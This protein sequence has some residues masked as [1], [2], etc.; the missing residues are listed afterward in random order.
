MPVSLSDLPRRRVLALL[1]SAA[2]AFVAA[3]SAAA[4][5]ASPTTPSSAH[6][7]L[8][9][10]ST[11]QEAYAQLI[12]AFQQTQAGTGV[13]IDTSFGASGTQTQ[14]VINGL[15]ADVVALSLE[16]D[17]NKLV[18]AG[19]VAPEWN[20]DANHGM[21]TDSVVVLVVRKGNPRNIRDW[22]DLL[23]PGVDVVTPDA[24]Q[25]GGAK[26]NL[27]AAY[28]AQVKQGASPDAAR[29]YL[30][31]LLGH[32]NVQ[33]ASARE[34]MTTFAGG[35]GDVLI[36]YENEAITAQHASQP[37]DYVVPNSTILIENPIAITRT[38]HNAAAAQAFVEYLRSADGQR[39]W[40]RLGYRPILQDIASEFASSFRVPAGQFTIADLGGWPNVDKQFF[41]RD[42]GMVSQILQELGRSGAR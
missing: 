31:G 10:Y 25:S 18:N 38:S 19:I 14:A 12:P 36:A 6:L 34:A 9:G 41:D 17:V 3:C 21:V 2:A 35:K 29:A 4:P 1:A 24:F 7:T 28:G 22:P 20:Q 26:W 32:V 5:Q 23:Q 39:L 27:L 33:P 11:P 16:S 13:S 40:G 42:N 8:V 37:V 15:D 30:K